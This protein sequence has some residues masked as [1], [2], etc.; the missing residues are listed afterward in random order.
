MGG[1]V[2]LSLASTIDN[3]LFDSPKR[4]G[5]FSYGSGCCSEFYSGVATPG[6]QERQRRFGI[7]SQL[8]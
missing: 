4:I 1:T 7:E 3:G 8:N 2:F 5:C 6:G